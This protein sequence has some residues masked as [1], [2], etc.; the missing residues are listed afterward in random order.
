MAFA[1]SLK[2]N[3][4]GLDSCRYLDPLRI[5]EIRSM[6]KEGDWREELI[7]SLKKDIGSMN[8]L[9]V[10]PELG[11]KITGNF[12]EINC[13]GRNY[14]IDMEGNIT[15]EPYN[16]WISI[17]LLHYIRNRGKGNLTDQ[18]VSFSELKG[19]LVK[20]STFKREC[21][22]PLRGLFDDMKDKIDS[23][24]ERVG[25][26]PVSGFPSEKS[27]IIDLLPKVRVLILYS[28]GDD[29]F[30]SS[31]KIVFDRITGNFL[32]VESIIFL[33]EGL[34]HTLRMISR[35]D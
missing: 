17:L 34:V 5:E 18:W 8:I 33:L 19:G 23:Y 35:A 24:L 2:T 9:E 31:L 30:P 11:A 13:I 20:S 6:L 25:A 3:Q 4:E 27:W 15:P 16:K 10:A 22:D 32:D 12:I 1:I 29:E 28:K 7:R 21:E 14:L 26:R